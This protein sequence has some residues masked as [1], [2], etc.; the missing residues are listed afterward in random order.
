MDCTSYAPQ[1][2]TALGCCNTKFLRPLCCLHWIAC[3]AFC[4]VFSLQ[5]A[6]HWELRT[7]SFKFEEF[8]DFGNGCRFQTVVKSFSAFMKLRT[9]IS[10]TTYSKAYLAVAWGTR[11]QLQDHERLSF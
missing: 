11:H 5:T 1:Q 10:T 3:R 9:G 4:R 7:R 6:G 2:E 8:H